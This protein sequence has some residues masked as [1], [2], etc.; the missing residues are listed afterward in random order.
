[1]AR[2]ALVTGGTGFL[3]RHVVERLVQE[4][5]RV[6]V[7]AR[8]RLDEPGVE[9]VQGSV[10]D[11]DAVRAAMKGCDA[12][13]HLAGRVDRDRRAEAAQRTLHVDGTRIV[14]GAAADAGVGRLV[15]LST[16]GVIACSTDPEA[17]P[18]E[19]WP[20]PRA[21]IARWPYY[22]TKLEAEELALGLSRE[23]GLPLVCLNPSL[24]LGPGDDDGSST[25]DVRA[26]VERRLPA[27]P[28][29]SLNFVDVRDC[30]TT[31]V[32]A[33]TRGEPGERYLVGGHDQSLDGFARTIAMLANVPAPR[34]RAP[35]RATRWAARLSER[36]TRPLGLAPPLNPIEVEI[37]QMNWRLDDRKAR[38]VLGHQ[39][40]DAVETL[41]E[42]VAWVVQHPAHR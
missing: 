5:W 42:T 14:V 39:P 41:R 17:R 24:L 38:R 26:V 31:T 27:I 35:D 2:T 25:G 12:V 6:R 36:L 1:M 18:D 4:G 34:L 28:S 13:L 32:A 3:G 37:S 8:R 33:L 29:G 9:S 40:R 15:Y 21:L 19:S 23:R 16:S 22:Q 20:T 11:T 7:L 30:A 10:L